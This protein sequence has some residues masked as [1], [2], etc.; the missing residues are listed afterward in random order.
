MKYSNTSKNG[1]EMKELGLNHH[2]TIIDALILQDMKLNRA[3]EQILATRKEVYS[4]DLYDDLKGKKN[5][6][7]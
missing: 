6:S 1:L 2:D 3:I 5:Q 4:D 7:D